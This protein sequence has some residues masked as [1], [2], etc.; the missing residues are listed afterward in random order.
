MTKLSFQSV[1]D[2]ALRCF[3]TAVEKGWWEDTPAE[4]HPLYVDFM[5]S[6]LAL[7]HS[8]VSEALEVLREPQIKD[9][10]LADDYFSVKVEGR[11]HFFA[12]HDQAV[13]FSGRNGT[14]IELAKPEGFASELADVIIRIF[15]L[16]GHL[17]IDMGAMLKLKMAYNDT[18]RYK[19]G[20][21]KI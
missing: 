9:A 11:E 12:D 14:A 13:A 5:A 21:K 3:V 10:K 8:E 1:Q 17:G 6:K 2:I 20:G 19:H 18:R 15:D 4:S 7:I 16:C